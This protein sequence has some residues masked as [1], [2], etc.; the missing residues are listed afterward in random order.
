MAQ[1]PGAVDFSVSDLLREQ[2]DK[3]K[4]ELIAGE[5]SLNRSIKVMDLNRPGL[6]L[7]GFL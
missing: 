2:R 1:R 7:S 4:L 5:K 3:L 6:A